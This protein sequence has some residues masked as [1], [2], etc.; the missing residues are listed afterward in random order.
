MIFSIAW[1]FLFARGRQAT[2]LA[3]VAVGGLTLG[4]LVLTTV[5]SVMNGFESTLSGKLVALSGEVTVNPPAGTDW[6]DLAGRLEQQE[7]VVAAA[8]RLTGEALLMAGGALA[9][10]A[11]QG[12]DADAEARVSAVDKHLSGRR[13]AALVPGSHRLIV[14]EALAEQLKLEI[15]DDV[16]LLTAAPSAGNRIFEPAL[17][18][19]QV[20]GIYHLGIYQLELH[21]AYAALGDVRALFPQAGA[22]SIVLRSA[23]P[24]A[25][26]ELSARLRSRLGAGYAVSDWTE[27]QAAL[28]ATIGLEKRMLFVVLAA[29]LAV[30][31]FAV[32]AT[33]L[34]AG[35]DREADIAV[36]KTLGLVPRRIAGVFLAQGFLLGA[37]GTALGL[38]LGALLAVNVN[39]LLGALD[40][41]F[42]TRLLPP[43]IYLISELPAEFRWP[44]LVVT[45]AVAIVLALAA[46]V[47][48][49]L[50]GARTAPADAL[51]YE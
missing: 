14:G 27:H 18:R 38:G 17:A 47:Y 24:L 32:V 45:A 43:S 26:P 16:T 39:N 19:F 22:P 33:L 13:L 28:F 11:L 40:Q 3:G 25:A 12:I 1:R 46:A 21:K 51:R 6:R 9:P 44:D 20:A 35:L 10:I 7:G 15:G 41:L 49:A 4:V 29:I 2:L 23:A 8:P 48:P 5:L 34:V 50:R 37:V 42:D 31:A 36:L 30:A